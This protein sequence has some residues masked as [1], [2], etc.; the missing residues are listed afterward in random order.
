MTEAE[1]RLSIYEIKVFTY[2]ITMFTKVQ[3]RDCHLDKQQHM[4][5]NIVCGEWQHLKM[6]NV[7]TLDTY[8]VSVHLS[9]QRSVIH[10]FML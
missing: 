7:D 1:I 6:M 9:S 2:E 4:T 5:K 8:Y 10:S 3:S